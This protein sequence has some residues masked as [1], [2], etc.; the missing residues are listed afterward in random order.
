MGGGGGWELSGV[1]MASAGGARCSM[2]MMEAEL[3]R[4]LL[5][6][7]LEGGPGFMI[8]KRTPTGMRFPRNENRNGCFLF[9]LAKGSELR[10][11]SIFLFL[12]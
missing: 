8:I 5:K 11:G 6:N 9:A 3:K 7:P 2:S 1:S 12:P 10:H 4:G